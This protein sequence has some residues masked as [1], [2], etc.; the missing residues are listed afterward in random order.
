MNIADIRQEYVR[1]GLS[2]ADAHADPFRQFERWFKDALEAGLPLPNAMTLATVSAGGSPSARVVL[3]KGIEPQDPGQERIAEQGFVFY[4]NYD[5]RKGRELAAMPAACL[6]FLWSEL[7]RQVRIDG[8][9][10]KMPGT[11]C[12]EYWRSRPIGARHS[13]WASA[14]S[15]IVPDRAALENALQ[16]VRARYGEDPPR[17]PHWGGYRVVPHALEFWQGRADRLHDRLL[18]RRSGRGWTIERLAP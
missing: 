14:Q 1:A 9:V 3:L 6:V 12:D 17:P 7:E 2:E 18:Y 5:S 13:A 8:R 16:A 4:T 11:A 15:V 10:E